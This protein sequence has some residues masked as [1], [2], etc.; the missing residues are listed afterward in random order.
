MPEGARRGK[1]RPLCCARLAP[2][3]RLHVHR[4]SLALPAP[5]ELDLVLRGHGW[6]A[7]PPHRYDGPGEPFSTP[8]RLGRDIALANVRQDGARLRVRLD[9]A[10]RLPARAIELARAQLAHVLRL[11]EDLSPF[12]AQCA[13]LP[14]HAWV[15]RRGGGRLLRSPTLFEDLLKLLFTTNCTWAA[16]TAMT[17]KLVEAIG[18]AGPGGRRAFPDAA[19][20]DR[21]AA[22]FRDVVRAGYRAEA[23][24]ELAA[25]CCAG[26]LRERD[27]TDPELPTAVVRQRLLALRGFGPYAAGQ[28][29]RLLG[30]YDDLAI[31]SWCRATLAALLGRRRP[32]SDTAIARRYRA[33]GPNAGLAMWCELTASWHGEPA[34][35]AMDARGA[36]DQSTSS[37]TSTFWTSSVRGASSTR[38]AMRRHSSAE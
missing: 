14:A 21:G 4:C 6:V 22:F 33:F 32:P 37:E 35:D 17:R 8:L 31:D 10:R 16:T 12:W 27:F 18:P 9:A 3:D 28:A 26:E 15:A 36:D 1:P 20:C 23:C 11:D 2:L 38:A 29:L 25:R 34:A 30:R 5:F 13:E 7:L 24:A 19:E